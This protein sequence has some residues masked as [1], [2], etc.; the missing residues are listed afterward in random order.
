MRNGF[1][2]GVLYTGLRARWG[3]AAS[4][5]VSAALFAIGHPVQDWLP[6]F[7][8]GVAFA[9]LRECRQSIVPGMVAHFLQNGLVFL[10]LSALFSR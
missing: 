3:V 7:G 1:F 8:L 4:I 10:T 6:I 5:I 2:R 9:A